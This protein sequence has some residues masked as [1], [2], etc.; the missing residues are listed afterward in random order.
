M[1]GNGTMFKTGIRK[2]TKKLDQKNRILDLTKRIIIATRKDKKV[3][4]IAT[5]S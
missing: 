2:I 5:E 4:Q 3:I 1:M